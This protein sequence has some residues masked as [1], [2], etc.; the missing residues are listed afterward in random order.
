VIFINLEARINRWR[1]LYDP[2]PE[3]PAVRYI[4][5]YPG[6]EQNGPVL[7]AENKRR[8]I[9]WA[10]RLYEWQ[11]RDAESFEDD[12]LPCLHVVTGTEIFAECFGCHVVYPQDNMPF[13]LPCV[14]DSAAASRLKTPKLEDTPLM[15]LFEIADELRRFAGEDALLRIPDMQCPV[16]VAALIWD[17]NDFFPAMIEE[18][19]AVLELA[20]K[21]QELQISFLD[22]WFM[23]YGT[24]Y[25][26]HYP[27]YYMEGGITMS[28]DEIGSV[29]PEM[30][31]TF[32]A[33]EIN[34]LSRRY[35]GV[36]IHCCAD[37]RKQWDNLR[38]VQGL[39]LLNLNLDWEQ[40]AQALVFF[41]DTCAQMHVADRPYGVPGDGRM[42][43]KSRA[44]I[45][46]WAR[47]FDHARELAELYAA[48]YG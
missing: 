40:I 32:F 12:S 4:I 2:H 30:F 9:D 44:V 24:R 41:K 31:R 27:N 1:Q 18:P 19:E 29:S 14:F 33:G 43:E 15:M 17:K 46:V 6:P 13:A 38:Q 5:T 28:V 22:E 7:N 45:P 37:S 34:A 48:A 35:G 36:G 8:R 21:A 47:D 42:P 16:D 23:R 3:K 11:I 20:E 39:R 10:K 25:I 26:A